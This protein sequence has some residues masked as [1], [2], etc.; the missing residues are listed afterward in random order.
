D[1]GRLVEGNVEFVGHDLT[2][3]RT[4]ALAEIGLADI[5]RRGVVRANR[6]PRVQLVEIGIGIRVGTWRRRLCGSVEEPLDAEFAHRER[7][8]A[9]NEDAGGF[10]EFAAFH[11][12]PAWSAGSTS[13]FIVLA[14]RLMAACTR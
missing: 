5:E 7:P 8:D 13:A 6:D 10:E 3:R 12:F 1:D 11:A 2:E 9:A 4:G 14:A